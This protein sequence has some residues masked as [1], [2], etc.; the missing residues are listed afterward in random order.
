M[1]QPIFQGCDRRR[2]IRHMLTLSGISL[3]TSASV[4]PA[5]VQALGKVPQKLPADQSIFRIK[6][7]VRVNGE[8]ATENS[9]ITQNALIE[10]NGDS[11]IIFVVGKDAHI[12]RKNSE[13]ILSAD[14]QSLETGAQ[15]VKGQLMSVFGER[16]AN[17]KH[18]T[19]TTTAT[20]GIRGTAVYAESELSRSYVCTC[21]GK[22]DLMAVNDPK[23]V[24]RIET[25]HHDSPRYVYATGKLGQ[26]IEPAPMKNHEDEEIMLIEALLGRKTPF[27][28]LNDYSVPSIDY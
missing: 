13:L 10:T 15:L 1:S 17:E 7:R 4:F 3:A 6:G 19:S 9:K 23:S 12:L 21:Y 11:E 18:T 26:L 28:S 25:V 27:S 24:E 2:F 16:A 8:L 20:I 14:K 5:L 22:V